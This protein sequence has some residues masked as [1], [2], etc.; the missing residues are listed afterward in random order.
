MQ[1][2]KLIIKDRVENTFRVK[3]VYSDSP[4]KVRDAFERTMRSCEDILAIYPENHENQF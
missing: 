4:Q 2:Y 3:S 1:F